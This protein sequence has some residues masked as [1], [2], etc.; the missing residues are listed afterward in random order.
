MGGGRKS[1]AARRKKLCP[2]IKRGGWSLR[3]TAKMFTF[4][5]IT[6]AADREVVPAI[7]RV[8]YRNVFWT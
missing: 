1:V 5:L 4:G 7:G 2:G 3:L 8:Q 6:C